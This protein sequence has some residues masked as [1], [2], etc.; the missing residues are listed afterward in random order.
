[1][2]FT[3]EGIPFPLIFGREQ[4][5]CNDLNQNLHDAFKQQIDCIAIPFFHPRLD[6]DKESIENEIEPLAKADT[7]V[8]SEKWMRNIIGKLSRDIDID[9]SN[10]HKNAK[11][12]FYL[13]QELN[14][15]VHLGAGGFIIPGPSVKS[16][17]YARVI[18]KVNFLEG[19]FVSEKFLFSS[20]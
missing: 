19:F 2:V 3:Y 9:T 11:S 13:K 10:P 4:T 14:Y 6:R 7:L 16:E 5:I 12:K 15:A 1:M 17:N 20:C 8:D 18:N